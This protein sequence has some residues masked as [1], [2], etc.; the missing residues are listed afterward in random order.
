MY[1]ES[2]SIPDS[3]TAHRW[4]LRAYVHDKPQGPTFPP[5]R[6]SPSLSI[7]EIKKF[8]GGTLWSFWKVSPREHGTLFPAELTCLR[9]TCRTNSMVLRTC[10][11]FLL[12]YLGMQRTLGGHDVA[13]GKRKKRTR[14]GGLE[15]RPRLWVVHCEASS[16]FFEKKKIL[17]SQWIRVEKMLTP[18][19]HTY[20]HAPNTRRIYPVGSR[21][22]EYRSAS[23]TH[24]RL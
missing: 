5:R 10:L 2:F 17:V 20:I 15:P 7:Q 14:I 23:N 3:R 19:P 16:K 8:K 18:A 4:Y 21:S 9:L 6:Q 12:R 22:R 11:S 1:P 13:L 24:I